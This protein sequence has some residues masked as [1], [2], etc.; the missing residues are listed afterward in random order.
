MV[1]SLIRIFPSVQVLQPPLILT[2]RRKKEAFWSFWSRGW[3]KRL[4]SCVGNQGASPPRG[5]YKWEN[6]PES[7]SYSFSCFTAFFL[8]STTKRKMVMRQTILHSLDYRSSVRRGSHLVKYDWYK[9]W[10]EKILQTSDL[11]CQGCFGKR[12]LSKLS[13]VFK[14]NIQKLF[15]L[16]NAFVFVSCFSVF[17]PICDM[18]SWLYLLH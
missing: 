17:L 9:T 1:E 12:D 8:T 10:G 18:C 11:L 2:R 7:A 14:C 15:V 16:Q 4:S 3:I 5:T 13:L 6:T